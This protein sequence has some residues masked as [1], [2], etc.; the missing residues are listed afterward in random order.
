MATEHSGR[1]FTLITEDPLDFE[2]DP[3]T[4]LVLVNFLASFGH[5]DS[6]MKMRGGLLLTPEVAQALL[7]HLPKLESILERAKKGRTKPDFLQ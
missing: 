6:T 3:D 1:G 4:G 7:D 5:L 2:F